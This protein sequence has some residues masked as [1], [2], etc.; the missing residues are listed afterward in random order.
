MPP[1]VIIPELVYDDLD[2][3]VA[4]LC[5]M[6]GFTERLRIGKHRSQLVFGGAAIVAVARRKRDASKSPDST[7]QEPPQ[8]EATHSIMVQVED[9]NQHYEYVKLC[10]GKITNPPT[11]YSYGERQ[12][13]VED[14]E[15]RLWTFSQS[16]ADI[17]PGEWGG[18]MPHNH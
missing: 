18:V 2:A 12:Y 9:V 13:T 3:A 7:P 6:F 8:R 11:D 14:T 1:G 10:G 5:N 4:W 17:D 15:G 16:I